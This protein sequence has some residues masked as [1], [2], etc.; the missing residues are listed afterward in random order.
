ME[1]MDKNPF[2]LLPHLFMTLMLFMFV[3]SFKLLIVSNKFVPGGQKILKYLSANVGV[4]DNHEQ[5]VFT[6]NL[7]A[8]HGTCST[9]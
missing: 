4:N 5:W 9:L 1:K 8:V 7:T 6:M 3:A 2:S